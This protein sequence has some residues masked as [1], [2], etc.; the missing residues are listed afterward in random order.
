MK[1]NSV[2]SFKDMQAAENF[3]DK[4]INKVSEQGGTS[5]KRINV[6]TSL[7]ETV[8]WGINTDNTD[9]KTIVIF[10]GFRT[11][12]LF[13][14][15][16]NAL[17]PLKNDFRI[18][19]VDTNGQPNLSEGK[20]PDIKTNDYGIWAAE[21]F[22]KLS[23][24]KAVIAGASFGALICLKLCIVAPRLVE[25]AILLNPGCLQSFSLSWKNLYYNFLPMISPSE[26]N[27]EKFLDN[28]VFYKDKH[29]V[30]PIA[31]KLIV[32][33]ELFAITQYKD[34][35]QKPYAMKRDELEDVVSEVYLVLGDKDLLF[36]YQKSINAARKYIQTL[37]GV[38][39]LGD[40]GHGIETSPKAIQIV[41]TIAAGKEGLL[42]NED[43][44]MKY[45]Q[46]L[47][48]AIERIDESERKNVV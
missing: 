2:S 33:Y 32:E 45:S 44:G 34:R 35:T 17:E 40:T 42:L 18:F 11:C 4:W 8:V 28:A 48:L 24:D 9:L 21:L 46:F 37:R 47:P 43:P 38:C 27:V 30:S 39:I 36:P 26:R 29:M 5:Y 16:D 12:C 14:D 7:G 1:I 31:K 41:T 20:T 19:L 23:I 10:P 25:K 22:K 6:K 15:M 3:F 13:W